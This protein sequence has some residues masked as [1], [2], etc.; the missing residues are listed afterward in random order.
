ML[1][2]TAAAGGG[3]DTLRERGVFCMAI[4][5]TCLA[6]RGSAWFGQGALVS[7]GSPAPPEVALVMGLLI[8][9]LLYV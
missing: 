5:T 8:L 9:R 2:S 6:K 4:H 3:D 7:T 1:I